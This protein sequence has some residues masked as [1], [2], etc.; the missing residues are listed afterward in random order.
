MRKTNSGQPDEVFLDT[1]RKIEEQILN[2][3]ARLTQE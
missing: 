3:K 1:I 2:L